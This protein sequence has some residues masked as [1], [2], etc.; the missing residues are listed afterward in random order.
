MRI[1][2]SAAIWPIPAAPIT[3]NRDHHR[4]EGPADHMGAETLGCEEDDQHADRHRQRSRKERGRDLGPLDRGY[5]R[6]RRGDHSVAVKESDPEESGPDQ[7][8]FTNRL[9]RL[10][11]ESAR[12]GP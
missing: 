12:S 3:M 6:D 7:P 5:D 4:P 9:P 1:S 10:A 8:A 2:G 11:P